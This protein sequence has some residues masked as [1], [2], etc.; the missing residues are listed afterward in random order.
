VLTGDGPAWRYVQES[1]NE[2]AD[3][4]TVGLGPSSDYAAP[5]P[6]LDARDTRGFRAYG[7]DLAKHTIGPAVRVLRELLKS[8][9]TAR[10]VFPHSVMGSIVE[11]VAARVSP[12]LTV[13]STFAD[14]GN[15][16]TS[17]LPS[18]VY[19]ARQQQVVKGDEVAIGWVAASG[20]KVS[21]IEIIQRL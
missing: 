10:V 2:L 7:R 4:C 8:V 21:A 16:A 6:R 19:R 18:C 13:F 12:D 15:I 11:E 14:Q 17:S 5:S 20:L 9:G 3:L 1:H